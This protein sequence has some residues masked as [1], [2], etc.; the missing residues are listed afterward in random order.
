M[1]KI[2]VIGATSTIAELCVRQWMQEDNTEI[3]L[4]GRNIE[5]LNVMSQD[6]LVRNPCNNIKI[7]QIDF[8]A[9]S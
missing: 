6:L 2:I 1:K 7:N 4:V 8:K 3:V 5:R 9:L